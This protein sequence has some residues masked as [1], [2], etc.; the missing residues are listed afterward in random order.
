MTRRFATQAEVLHAITQRLI[1]KIDQYNE[2]SCF[3][4]DQPVPEELPIGK[5]CC[6]VSPGPGNFVPSLFGGAGIATLTEDATAV[7]TPLV[8]HVRGPAGRGTV[9][10]LNED[11]GLV[12][13]KWEIL[14][15]LLANDYDLN[16]DGRYLLRDQLTP[17]SAAAPGETQIGKHKMLGLSITFHIPFD[18]AIPHGATVDV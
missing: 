18:W 17:Q 11:D 9:K 13:R 14:Q 3:V 15:A 7:V 8:R 16:I 6:T 4:L 1:D 5:E 2:T 10:L 12:T